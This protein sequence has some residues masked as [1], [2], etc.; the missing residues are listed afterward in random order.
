MSKIDPAQNGHLDNVSGSLPH[1]QTEHD[2]AVYYAVIIEGWAGFHKAMYRE[3][4]G[5]CGWWTNFFSKIQY[6]VTKW[7]DLTDR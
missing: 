1:A 7:F 4:D 5:E 2:D 3:V 6:P